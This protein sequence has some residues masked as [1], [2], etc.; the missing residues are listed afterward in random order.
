MKRER[1]DGGVSGSV[2]VERANGIPCPQPAQ[3]RA[4][5]SNHHAL[6][7]GSERVAPGDVR[8]ASPTHSTAV[9]GR[10]KCKG[11]SPRTVCAER[12]AKPRSG[13]CAAVDERVVR[14][15]LHVCSWLMV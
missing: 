14:E 6:T 15:R 11:R 10:L 8:H 12:A 9:G 4:R 13:P 5:P 2:G 3:S 7:L 1:G